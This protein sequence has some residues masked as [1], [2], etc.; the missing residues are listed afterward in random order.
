[1]INLNTTLGMGGS[2]QRTLPLTCAS[3]SVAASGNAAQAAPL[4]L[5]EEH[6]HGQTPWELERR[7]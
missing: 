6:K 4:P 1:M 7:K 3:R 5:V 2:M